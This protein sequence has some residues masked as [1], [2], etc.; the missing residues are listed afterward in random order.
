MIF[1]NDIYP[2]DESQLQRCLQSACPAEHESHFTAVLSSG[3][4]GRASV[5]LCELFGIEFCAVFVTGAFLWLTMPQG[6]GVSSL[7]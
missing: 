1:D 4:P 5:S 2:F 3:E 7:R 6:S